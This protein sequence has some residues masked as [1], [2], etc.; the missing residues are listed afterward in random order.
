MLNLRPAKIS[1]SKVYVQYNLRKSN[2]HNSNT[3]ANLNFF[4]TISLG[5]E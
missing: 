4:N 1:T 2:S 5:F 3:P